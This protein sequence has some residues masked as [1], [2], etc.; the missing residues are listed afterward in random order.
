ME[1]WA[2]KPVPKAAARQECIEDLYEWRGELEERAMA[3]QV[4][5]VEGCFSELAAVKEQVSR[6]E[7]QGCVVVALVEQW[8]AN[9]SETQA[10]GLTTREMVHQVEGRMTGLVTGEQLQQVEEQMV[11][12]GSSYERQEVFRHVAARRLAAAAGVSVRGRFTI[13]VG[14]IDES[15]SATLSIYS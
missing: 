12:D 2:D 13:V 5:P 15:V 7:Q 4:Q 6:M 8:Q 1:G 14:A 9:V 3:A 11:E 10:G